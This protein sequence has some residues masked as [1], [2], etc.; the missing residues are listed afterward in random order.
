LSRTF[1]TLKIFIVGAFHRPQRGGGGGPGGLGGGGG[2][3][4][5]KTRGRW[6]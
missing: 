1:F 4:V 5:T 3:Q 2:E 6:A